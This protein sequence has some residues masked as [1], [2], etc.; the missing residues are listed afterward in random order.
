MR[1]PS[2]DL[3]QHLGDG[4]EQ[5]ARRDARRGGPPRG[6]L[7]GRRPSRPGRHLEDPV[8]Q[9]GPDDARDEPGADA[10]DRVGGGGAA[11][12]HRREGRLHGEDLELRPARPE[13]LADAGDVAAGADA[14]DDVVEAVGEVAADLLG[15]GPLV[16]LEVGR[17]VE[18]HRDPGAGRLGDDLVG[19]G[20]RALHAQLARGQLELRTVGG[21]Q[22]AALDRHRLGHRR[23]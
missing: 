19:P 11:A 14:G 10:L 21:H 15:R 18:L 4:R 9:V 8:E 7:A 1:A 22:L 2:G 23:G 16:D 5:R 13:D 12:Q 6:R 3:R 20:D 17:V